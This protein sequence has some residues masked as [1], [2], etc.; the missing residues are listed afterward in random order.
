VGSIDSR[1]RRLE[2]SEAGNRCP[3]CGLASDEHRPIAAVYAEEPDKGFRGDTDERC[4]RCGRN[5]YTVLRVVRD[6]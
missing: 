1:L 2:D 6:G 5:L 4:G 3:A